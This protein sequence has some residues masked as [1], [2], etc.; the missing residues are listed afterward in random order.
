MK[1][2]FFQKYK[3]DVLNFIILLALII[4]VLWNTFNN[5]FIGGTNDLEPHSYSFYYL[6]ESLVNYGK[7][8]QWTS[9]YF[10]GKPFLGLYQPFT[11][12]LFLPVSLF[13]NPVIVPKIVFFLIFLLSVLFFYL[14]AKK[15][16]NNS[17]KALL[18]SIIFTVFPARL[19][20]TA[21]GVLAELTAIIFIPIAFLLYEKI[22]ESPKLRYFALLA[23]TQGFALLSHHAAGGSLFFTL[24]VFIAYDYFLENKNTTKVIPYL[25][26]GIIMSLVFLIP[27]YQIQESLNFAVTEKAGTSF[28]PLDIKNFFTRENSHGEFIGITA[29]ILILSSLSLAFKKRDQFTKYIIISFTFLIVGLYLHFLIPSFIKGTLQFASRFYSVL[30][31]TLPLLIILGVENFSLYL[32]KLSKE[33]NI[34]TINEKTKDTAKYVLIALFLILIFFSYIQFKPQKGNEL[35]IP[36]GVLDFYQNISANQDYYRVEDQVFAPFGFSPILHKHGILNGA[37]SQEAPKYHFTLWATAWQLMQSESGAQNLAGL[38]GA[39]SIKYFVAGGQTNIPYFTEYKCGY[40]YCIYENQKFLPYIRT[41][42]KVININLKEPDYVFAF[43]DSLTK[44]IVPFDKVAFARNFG[45]S[46]I[47]TI[48]LSQPK[49]ALMLVE[50]SPGYLKIKI[51]NLNNQEYLIVSE[52]YH[53]YWKAY[54]NKKEIPIYE[55]VPSTLV[56]PIN[57]NGNLEIKYTPPKIKYILFWLTMLIMLALIAMAAYDYKTKK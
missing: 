15:L 46:G 2:S 7:I 40:R 8:P 29:F 13:F 55:G 20:M 35:S 6:K 22:K 30:S 1:E 17:T 12:F 9:D 36:N 45:L 33:Y 28:R 25:V 53:P 34:L 43:L 54:L 18:A 14:L 42:S 41:V 4:F 39:L 27:A 37:P 47:N 52:S 49:A 56:I 57:E 26:I 38:Y 21:S 24:I 16:F 48:E 32:I 5:A 50:K 3:K 51:G 31:I 23:L 11:Y 10:G 19:S 44:F